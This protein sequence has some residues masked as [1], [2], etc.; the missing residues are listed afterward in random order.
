MSLYKRGK[1]WWMNL[2]FEGSHVQRS[3]RCKSKRDAETVERAY[4]TQLAKS[5]VGIEPKKA[6]PNFGDAIEDFL[7]W[8]KI[9]HAAKPN[10]YIR[11]E[12][13]TG[14]LKRF[15]RDTRLDRISSNDVEKYKVWRSQQTCRPRGK[16]PKDP[17]RTKKAKTKSKVLAPATVNRELAC[18]KKMLNRLVREGYC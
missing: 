6:V 7:A 13:S 17:S 9:E 11:Y 3:T 10:T 16:K 8:S 15:F 2:W 4:Y 5:E 18:L 12:T 14:P 1:T